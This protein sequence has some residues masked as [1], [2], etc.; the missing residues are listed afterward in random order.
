MLKCVENCI[1]RNAPKTVPWA[2]CQKMFK[3]TLYTSIFLRNQ[4]KKFTIEPKSYNAMLL[5]LF[6][7]SLLSTC[8]KKMETERWFKATDSTLQIFS[9][10]FFFFFLIKL[11]KY[12]RT[13]GEER[14]YAES[15]SC[16]YCFR[17]NPE[18][19]PGHYNDKCRRYVRMK[20]MIAK[21]STQIEDYLYAGEI[22]GRILDCA[23]GRIVVGDVE[24]RQLDLRIDNQRIRHVPDENEILSRVWYFSLCGINH[25]LTRRLII[26]CYRRRLCESW[27]RSTSC[28]R[29]VDSFILHSGY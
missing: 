8:P 6:F 26:T 4:S 2:R 29:R 5:Y 1:P 16:R 25:L 3:F 21:S 11:K 24:L 13:E 20:E 23:V 7:D 19:D 18:C 28:R 12:E 15:N 10:H 9:K 27:L 14:S 22:S 17:F